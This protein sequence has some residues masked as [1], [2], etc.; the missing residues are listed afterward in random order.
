MNAQSSQCPKCNTT[1]PA[2]A[3]FCFRCGEP[4]A[5][6]PPAQPRRS[7]TKTAWLTL[8]VIVVVFGACGICGIIGKLSDRSANR[9]T[10]N[11]NSPPNP[12]TVAS[13]SATPKPT[14]AELQRRAESLLTLQKEE[15]V[16]DDLKSYDAAIGPLK[17]IPKEAKEYSAAQS[18]IKKLTER[19]ARVTAEILVLG[20]K[21]TNSTYDGRVDP[22]VE[23]LKDNLNDYDSSEFVEWSPVTK[24]EVKGEP[25]WVVRLKLRAKNAF[26][27][28]I[29]KNTFY[30][31]RQNKVV[32]A[33]GL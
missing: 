12:T 26:G 17:E 2:D 21:P 32:S 9:A 24:I 13:P 22:V 6:A 11:S 20:P 27:G 3:R 31:I 23:Y 30:F 5:Q 10:G 19:A 33:A 28:Y 16:E 14:F 18:L 15:Y 7:E 4:F 1:N 25:F 8:G 29:L